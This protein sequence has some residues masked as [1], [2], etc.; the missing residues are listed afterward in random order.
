MHQNDDGIRGRGIGRRGALAAAAGT[1]AALLTGSGARP[2]AAQAFPNRPIRLV[3]PYPAGGGVD[4]VGRILADPMGRLLGQPVVVDNRAGAAGSIGIESV[5]RSAPDGYT[6]GVTA[7]GPVTV[8]PNLRPH[9]YD[10]LK[11]VH[12]ARLT[13]SPLLLIARKTLPARTVAELAALVKNRPDTVR[14][15]SGGVGTG[16]HMAAELFA[17]RAGGKMIHVPYRGTAPA[18]TDII[19]GNVDIFF[20]DASALAQV[21]RGE[22]MGLAVTTAQRW[23][24][25]PSLPAIGET[26]QGFDVANWYGLA[27]PEGMPADIVRKL[28]DTATAAM[29]EPASTQRVEAGGFDVAPQD[30][31]A[32]TAFIRQELATWK[33]VIQRAHIKLD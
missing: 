18:V 8:G 9:P 32:F 29:A 15:A 12:V 14:F 30:S 2:A 27:G 20:S 13:V 17:L 3:V 4:L 24:R 10:P 7:P 26:I 6:L 23:K 22:V 16:T 28:Q 1:G 5:A 21:Q 11:L 33:D 19:A 25:L 31:A